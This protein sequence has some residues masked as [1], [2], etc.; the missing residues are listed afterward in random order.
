MQTP[1]LMSI[2]SAIYSACGVLIVLYTYT[3]VSCKFDLQPIDIIVSMITI[4]SGMMMLVYSIFL[5]VKNSQR[6]I[7]CKKKC[8]G[9]DSMKSPLLYEDAFLD[10]NKVDQVL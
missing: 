4:A 1:W 5:N 2:I 3:S 9:E 8:C 10:F 6:F 7:Q